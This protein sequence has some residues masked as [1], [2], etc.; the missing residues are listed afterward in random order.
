M[1]Q[2]A[3]MK[4]MKKAL[5]Q[6]PNCYQ[7]DEVFDDMLKKKEEALEVKKGD[8]KAKYIDSLLKTAKH[9]EL[10]NELRKEREA[11]R[12]RETEGDMYSD[13]EAFVTSGFKKKMEELR[14]MQE[15]QAYND[16]IDGKVDKQFLTYK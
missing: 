9:R 5:E 6:D 12:E 3:S 16:A 1:Q 14:K 11:Q 7:Y 2:K 4:V 10:E 8:K 15:D 13:K